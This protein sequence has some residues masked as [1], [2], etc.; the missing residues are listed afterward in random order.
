MHDLHK[1]FVEFTNHKYFVYLQR[2]GAMSFDRADKN[3][4]YVRKLGKYVNLLCCK[5]QNILFPVLSV[6]Y[7]LHED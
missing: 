1:F 4:Q 2:R 3:A 5:T 7:M 6:C